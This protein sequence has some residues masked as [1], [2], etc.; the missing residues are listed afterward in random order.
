MIA[1]KAYDGSRYG[2]IKEYGGWL[3]AQPKGKNNQFE[4]Y[5]YTGK[6]ITG[7]G[8][9]ENI[10]YVSYPKNG[11]HILYYGQKDSWGYTNAGMRI[12]DENFNLIS[13]EYYDSLST[14]NE[15]GFAVAENETKGWHIINKEG[16]ALQSLPIH[17]IYG[18]QVDYAYANE[19]MACCLAKSGMIDT[20]YGVVDLQ[21]GE[22]TT[23]E[24]V[25]PVDGTNCIIVTDIDT[26]LKGL[27]DKNS[28]VL[29][30]IY[31]DITYNGTLF[32]ITRGGTFD[33]YFS[34]K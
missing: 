10:R 5:D 9:W 23:W 30:C 11:V 29:D 1:S 16:R 7:V 18:V 28:M 20:Y 17:E 8:D 25:K 33:I 13:K 24:S 27:Y 21:T 22:M 31:Q 6:R 4:L 3:Y 34:S 15:L 12:A 32:E 14:F 26:G 2:E 19:Y